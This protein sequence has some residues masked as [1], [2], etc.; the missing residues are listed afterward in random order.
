MYMRK[1]A[2]ISFLLFFKFIAI[3][4]DFKEKTEAGKKIF[5]I[6][7]L[8]ANTTG[9][10]AQY[11]NRHYETDLNKV[12][13]IYS[14]VTAN[15]KYDTDSS[16][17]INTGV[18][19]DAKITVAF[20][21]RKGVCENFAAIFNDICLQSGL[22]SFV[23][24]GYTKQGGK[25]DKT[26]HVWCAVPINKNWY[27]FDPTWDEGNE[28]SPKYFM[29]PPSQFIE[30]HM[31]FDQL[32]Q[33][34]NY[35]ITHEQFYRGNLFKNKNIPY[36]NFSDSVNAYIQ[37]D[38]LQKLKSAV[39]R[40]EK[41]GIYNKRIEENF[42]LLKSNIEMMR[43]DE[44]LDFYNS[45]VEDLNDATAI[46]NNFVEYHNKQ[47]IPEKSDDELKT[48]LDGIETKIDSSL[49]K[50]DEVDKSKAKLVFGTGLARERLNALLKKIQEQKDFLTR[51]LNTPK[52]DR[53]TLFY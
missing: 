14:W 51:Y 52:I 19:P 12:G 9:D 5:N 21:R 1:M 6:S 4:Q 36:L 10:V 27:L 34:L 44:E 17:I 22:T 38:S 39:I 20:K 35:P 30:S 53:N 37:M 16:R 43:Q 45:A 23:I 32:W 29:A 2:F 33:L 25:V 3:A 40:I 13:A 24:N 41:L 7:K 47:F 18:Y 28:M 26:G 50:L 48:L 49:Q 31:P 42:K 46:L 11:V 15:M 8:P